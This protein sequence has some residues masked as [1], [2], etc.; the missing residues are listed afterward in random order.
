MPTRF[1]YSQTADLCTQFGSQAL[2]Q[3]QIDNDNSSNFGSGF[4]NETVLI[5]GVFTVSAYFIFDNCTI[6]MAAGASIVVI[7]NSKLEIK[8]SKIFSCGAM[9]NGITVSNQ[10]SISFWNNTIEDAFTALEISNPSN[11]CQIINNAFNLNDIAIHIKDSDDLCRFAIAGNSFNESDGYMKNQSPITHMDNISYAGIMLSNCPGM[12]ILGL[13]GYSNNIFYRRICL[14]IVSDNSSVCIRRCQFY[15][16]A[17]LF[18]S[19]LPSGRGVYA[20]NNSNVCIHGLGN[21]DPNTPTFK[22]HNITAVYGNNSNIKCF[23]SFFTQTGR[24][25]IWLEN[26]NNH[27]FHIINNYFHSTVTPFLG[28]GLQ[29][30]IA[31]DKGA[32]GTNHIRFNNFDILD[33]K[34]IIKIV[35]NNNSNASMLI[36]YNGDNGGVNFNANIGIEFTAGTSSNNFIRNNNLLAKNDDKATGIYFASATGSIPGTENRIQDNLIGQTQMAF[37]RGINVGSTLNAL[38]CGNHLLSTYTG[39]RL[40]GNCMNTEVGENTFNGI[41]SNSTGLFLDGNGINLGAGT[42]N[43]K[44]NVWNGSFASLSAARHSGTDPQLSPFIVND[45]PNVACG[46]PIFWP[47]SNGISAVTPNWFQYNVGCLNSCGEQTITGG[48]SAGILDALDSLIINETYASTGQSPV[49]IWEAE[50][51]EYRKLRNYANAYAS[52]ALA[53]SFTNALQG[54]PVAQFYAFEQLVT[55]GLNFSDSIRQNLDAL[56]EDYTTQAELLNYA[57]E[58]TMASPEDQNLLTSYLNAAA[59]LRAVQQDIDQW[60]LSGNQEKTAKINQAE[61]LHNQ[62]TPTNDFELNLKN[63][64]KLR[65]KKYKGL[66]YNEQDISDIKEIAVKCYEEA[67]QAIFFAR[68]LLPDTLAYDLPSDEEC[69]EERGAYKT[70]KPQQRKGLFLYPNPVSSTLTVN[71]PDNYLGSQMICQI[72]DAVG[73]L[74]RRNTLAEDGTVSVSDLNPGVYFL[75]VLSDGRVVFIERF[76]KIAR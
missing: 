25:H 14:Q 38:I 34:S 20:V 72:Y 15:G 49:S 66:D 71:G 63:I 41:G 58:A 64:N 59:G 37:K 40:A 7:N 32:T 11:Y 19:A 3:P 6:R 5:S 55:E 56:Y 26:M 1:L 50:Y 54:S 53:N 35:D 44:G 8:N 33:A 16:G 75:Q 76:I 51:S 18:A 68:A 24:F 45:N 30:V 67:G 57:H 46:D 27:Y 48:G 62:I 21:S 28:T 73:R 9:W 47:A 60:L 42:N 2:T 13:N 31:S 17:F 23:N 36:E 52:N 70:A 29:H 4:T 12:I 10:S 61:V 65:L 43:H 69:L 39:I 74:I 22:Y